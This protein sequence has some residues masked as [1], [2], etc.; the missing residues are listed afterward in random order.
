VN[1]QAELMLQLGVGSD[2]SRKK[3]IFINGQASSEVITFK[4]LR[5]SV[6]AF[7]SE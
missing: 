7:F 6:Q 5:D 4:K 2:I 1:E 3:S